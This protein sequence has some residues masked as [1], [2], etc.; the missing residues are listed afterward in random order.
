MKIDR[1]F[2]IPKMEKQ[3]NGDYL[4]PDAYQNKI[5]EH[6]SEYYIFNKNTFNAIPKILIDML[7]EMIISKLE[8]SSK[9]DEQLESITK[10][11]D[12]SFIDVFENQS[13]ISSRLEELEKQPKQ[14][15][16]SIQ[17]PEI[18]IKS[19]I[20]SIVPPLVQQALDLFGASVSEFVN[21]RIKEELEKL[22]KQSTE[23]SQLQSTKLDP[24]NLLMYKK[25]GLDTKDLIELAKSGLV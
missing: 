4:Y 24:I 2:E 14:S 6:D 18:N 10:Q 7:S 25:L 8:A 3:T 17:Q 9:I 12:S 5:F 22:P 11:I 20:E 16:E 13:N 1:L 19:E 23:P 15:I 21:N